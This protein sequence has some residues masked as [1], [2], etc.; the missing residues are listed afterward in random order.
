MFPILRSK[1]LGDD[2]TVHVHYLQ[3][4]CEEN[5]KCNV[6]LS[7]M[8]LVN[9]ADMT[10]VHLCSSRKQ[11]CSSLSA[12][13]RGEQMPLVFLIEKRWPAAPDAIVFK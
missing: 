8:L 12:N 2:L 5:C 10:C 6:C 11:F 1:D 4:H 7:R 9:I 3:F 13:P